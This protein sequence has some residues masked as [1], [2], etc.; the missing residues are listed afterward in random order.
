MAQAFS[1]RMY[2]FAFIFVGV[3]LLI[4]FLPVL[5]CSS[6]SGSSRYVAQSAVWNVFYFYTTTSNS[7]WV[8]LIVSSDNL[9]EN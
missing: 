8:E 3:F 9:S 5:F 7:P 1:A 6:R 2:V 4:V